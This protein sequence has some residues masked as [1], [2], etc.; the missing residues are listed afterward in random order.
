MVPQV[1]FVVDLAIAAAYVYWIGTSYSR[2]T[3]A[4]TDDAV[5]L[6]A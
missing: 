4:R 6:A 1:P 3:A 5:F 2:A